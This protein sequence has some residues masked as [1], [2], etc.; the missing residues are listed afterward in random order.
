P[1]SSPV[2]K[3]LQRIRDESH[4]FAVSY[5]TQLKVKSQRQ[6][7]LDNISG[8]G[9]VSKSKLLKKYGTI[10]NISKAD[11]ID[12]KTLVGFRRANIIKGNLN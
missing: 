12:L 3:L 2:I 6:S 8:I 10:D 1:K 11:F 7:V 5:H 4:R 9:P